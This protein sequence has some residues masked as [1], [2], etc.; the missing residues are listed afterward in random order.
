MLS[1][2]AILSGR[3]FGCFVI[4]IPEGPAMC[5]IHGTGE[6]KDL[7]RS[8]ISLSEHVGLF[9][10]IFAAASTPETDTRKYRRPEF[11]NRGPS[12]LGRRPCAAFQQRKPFRRRSTAFIIRRSRPHRRPSRRSALPNPVGPGR[13]TADTTNG[14]PPIT[15][16]KPPSRCG[17]FQI[18]GSGSVHGMRIP[19][20]KVAEPG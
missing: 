7:K 6:W 9:L 17:F 20:N 10:M 4:S 18:V 8:G 13:K 11:L 1:A 14:A 5:P 12:A 16:K 15:I 2:E 3:K 19:T